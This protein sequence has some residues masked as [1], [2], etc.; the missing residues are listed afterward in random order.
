MSLEKQ[1]NP[2]DLE[3]LLYIRSEETG[4]FSPSD[5]ETATQG[6]PGVYT[7][8][9]PPPNVT[10]SL[11]IGHALNYTLQDILVRYHRMK[12][13]KTL[14]Q[15]G[16]DHAGIATQMVVTR[17]L[18]KQGLD[19]RTLG[20]E[21]FLEHVWQW[22]EKYGGRIVEQQ[23]RLGVTADWSRERF[24][25]DDGL[26]K[27]VRHVFVKL[28]HDGLIYRQKRLVNWDIKLQTAVSDLEVI[29][30]ET[31]GNY[32]TIKYPIVGEEGRYICVATTRPETLFGDTG[33]AVHPEDERYQD[34]IG[35][36]AI[37]PFV[38]REVPIVADEHC[39][40]EK[41]TG[42]VKITPAHDFND[43]DVG[44]RHNLEQITILDF[45]GH[46]IA[47][48]P[49]PFVGLDRKTARALVVQE[50]E[51]CG[52]LDK[53]EATTHMVPYGERSD[54]VL[55]PMLMDQWF[56]D[57]SDLA[58]R[59]LAAVNDGKTK[60]FPENMKN[61]YDHWLKNIQPW[62]IS[63]QLWWGHQIPVWYGPDHTPFVAEN[64]ASAQNLAKEHYGHDVSLCQ[65]ED[66]LDTWFSSALWPFSTLG[67]P[68]ETSPDLKNFYPTS[69]LSTGTDILF[70]WVARMMMMGLYCMDEVPF[71][72]VFLHALVRDEHGQKMSKTKG[73]VIDPMDLIDEFGAD[74]LR[75]T[76]SSLAAPGREIRFAKQQ[77]EA[78]RNFITKLWNAARFLEGS[79]VKITNDLNPQDLTLDLSKWLY[80]ELLDCLDS[81]NK[82][83]KDYRFDELSTT[84]YRFSWS[85][86]C[87][88]ALELSKPILY[89]PEDARRLE[90]QKVLGFVFGKLLKMLQPIIPF[91]TQHIFDHLSDLKEDLIQASWPELAPL[92]DQSARDSINWLIFLIQQIRSLRNEAAIP[93]GERIK[94]SIKLDQEKEHTSLLKDNEG[95]IKTLA[96]LE[97]LTL[98]E[99]PL[100][101]KSILQAVHQNATIYI[102]LDGVI[103]IEAE[104]S[105]LQKEIQIQEKE[106]NALNAKL[107]NENFIARAPGDVVEK[108]KI[109]LE[110]AR[111]LQAKLQAAFKKL[112]IN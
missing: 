31:Q 22:K 98:V 106:I 47:P 6:A 1:Y 80:S 107:S 85:V 72:E 76:M 28:Y 56:V 12:G 23:R 89:A 78:N 55:E 91:I 112:S 100:Q 58:K 33:I 96:R 60:L 46:L 92:D 61:T 3:P 24:T 63:R 21:K 17:E 64:E 11:H 9:M 30:R 83:I 68:D 90:V 69:V 84:L 29:S 94:V 34:L 48:T 32:W 20:R 50:L 37:V 111:T 95:L 27:A 16:T 110:E 97:T 67:W 45:S 82:H 5:K 109:R 49:K 53:V 108:N 62:C 41:G 39:D 77:V 87:D 99:M 52:L 42:A 105:R 79:G 36:K 44:T 70:F 14:W 65:D 81:I 101:G 59:S 73:N 19:R 75:F 25:M 40:R 7:I 35:K 54:D 4:A 18:A 10:G 74:A 2:Q 26:S 93:A 43:Y 86:F 88:W 8:M 51:A 71:K 15:P 13:Y 103:D 102:D 38:N 66:V 104:K 57:M